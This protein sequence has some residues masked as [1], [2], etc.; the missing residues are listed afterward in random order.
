MK[1]SKATKQSSGQ[2]L[3]G[4]TAAKVVKYLE[5]F[6]ELREVCEHHALN[7]WTKNHNCWHENTKSECNA[8]LCPMK[9]ED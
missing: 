6:N 8:I 3:L 9:G 7:E 4:H 5:I 1:K 2:Y